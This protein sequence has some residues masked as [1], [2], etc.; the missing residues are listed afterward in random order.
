[1]TVLPPSKIVI[2]IHEPRIYEGIGLPLWTLYDHPSDLPE[3]YVLRLFDGMTA[4][5]TDKIFIAK[6]LQE[7]DAA[8][9]AVPGRFFRMERHERDDPK[10][11]CTFI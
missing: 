2:D 9:E 6:S 11:I 5:P 3:H 1:M 4:E 10:I 7:I 8:L